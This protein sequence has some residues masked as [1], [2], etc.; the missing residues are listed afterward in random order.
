MS[1]S[2]KKDRSPEIVEKIKKSARQNE[3]SFIEKF[4]ITFSK[5]GV[6]CY[7]N[8]EK[9]LKR[10]LGRTPDASVVNLRLGKILFYIEISVTK[11]YSLNTFSKFKQSRVIHIEA[12]KH[13]AFV[14][15]YKG[16]IVLYG[17]MD[18]E[19]NIRFAF[20][21]DM[22]YRGVETVKSY[23][24]E[25]KTEN[26]VIN[27]GKLRKITMLRDGDKVIYGLIEEF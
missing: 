22:I 21:R 9:P 13:R 18:A 12:D 17:Y 8:R 7:H 4:N 3:D 10:G 2:W 20:F 1:K 6:K 5:Y 15:G 23:G 19:D 24:T 16:A 26:Y 14:S 27:A 11:T 25:E